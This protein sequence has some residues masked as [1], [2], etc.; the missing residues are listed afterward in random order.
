MFGSFP[1]G[2]PLGRP[3]LATRWGG[4]LR[5][6]ASSTAGIAFAAAAVVALSVAGVGAAGLQ[7]EGGR[8]TLT[9][10]LT[11]LTERLLDLQ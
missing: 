4:V 1:R 11:E 8:F 6:L 7:S 9:V 10:P 5:T 3:E 2:L